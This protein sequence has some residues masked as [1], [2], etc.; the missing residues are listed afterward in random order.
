VVNQLRIQ[1][2]FYSRRPDVLLFVN[3]IPLV[4][5]E[6]KKPTVNI[7]KA[8]DDNLQDYIETIPQL[9][10]YNLLVILSNGTETK[11]GS[12]SSPW[13]FFKDWKRVNESESGSTMIDVAV[14]SIANKSNLIDLLEN[15]VLYEEKD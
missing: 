12:Y 2:D 3:G 8:F 5:I 7:E 9:Y 6:L 4:Q 10:W 1:G 11:V 15:F 14:K 13:S